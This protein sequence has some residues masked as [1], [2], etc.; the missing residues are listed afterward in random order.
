MSHDSTA[1]NDDSV[2]ETPESSVTHEIP[3]GLRLAA[4]LAWRLLLVALGLAVVWQ[5]CTWL[6]ELVIPVAVALLLAGLLLPVVRW[7]ALRRVPR[8]LAS[9]IVLAGG[10]SLVGGILSWVISTIVGGWPTLQ[11]QLVANISGLR[12]WL[13]FGPLQLNDQQL[14][15][16]F[17]RIIEAFGTTP[18]GL[19]SRAIS[20][21]GVLAG[22]L[23]GGLL[24]L[25]T[26]FFLLRD[27]GV[28]W[29][30]VLRVFVP[31]HIRTRVDSAGRRAFAA[32]VGLV[33]AT[34][35]VAFMDALGIGIGAALVGVPLAPVLAAL[36]FLG[37]FIPYVGSLLAGSIVVLLAMAT[38]GFFA[39]LIVL[40]IV[41]GVMQLEGH[42]F[43]PLFLG[44][45]VRIHPVA[46]VFA[47]TAGFLLAGVAGAALAVPVVA[48]IS[49]A[50]RSWTH[51][52]RVQPT[53]IDP[54]SSRHAEPS[55]S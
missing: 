41:V 21:A 32:L 39:G 13:T 36:V 53:A 17:E 31:D 40:A 49:A 3:R 14:H 11:A 35:L 42:V 29:R 23:G 28:M 12:R 22:F 5:V 46:V 55:S 8:T 43:Q 34:A 52:S 4:A 19:T 7:L 2:R 38:K 10:L 47:I 15:G 45:A 27:S 50:A 51:D 9:L 18:A 24:G 37:A 16:I 48:V 30:F 20:T 25:F 33:R 54:Y 26:L 44:R 6:Y 1:D